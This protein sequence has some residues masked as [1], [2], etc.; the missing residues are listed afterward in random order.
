[1]IQGGVN[2]GIAL[3]VDEDVFP[4]LRRIDGGMHALCPVFAGLWRHDC[5]GAESFGKSLDPFIL[6][7]DDNAIL[8]FNGLGDAP[9]AL[10]HAA[11]RHDMHRLAGKARGTVTGGNDDGGGHDKT[12]NQ[13]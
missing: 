9:D 11:P 4:D 7:R 3:K 13:K 5:L 1:M 2:R 8:A 6:G 10:Q 12:C